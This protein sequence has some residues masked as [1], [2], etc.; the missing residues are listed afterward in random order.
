MKKCRLLTAVATLLLLLP[1]YLSA[2]TQRSITRHIQ[3]TSPSRVYQSRSIEALLL[4]GSKSDSGDDDDSDDDDN[5][6]QSGTRRGVG[7]RV[8]VFSDNNSRT[9]KNEARSKARNISARFPEH[10]TYVIY[11]SPY[12][13]LKVGDFRSQTEAN[14]FAEEIRK[15]FPSYAKE[16]R[17]VRDRIT[18]N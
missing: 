12:W 8:Q 18:V 1:P 4:E 3:S 17:V 16:V 15:A 7:Y 5:G 14:E 2:D 6:N 10:R 9:A 11:N 13:R